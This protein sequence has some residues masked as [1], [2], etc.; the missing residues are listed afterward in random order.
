MFR[1]AAPV[2]LSLMLVSLSGPPRPAEGADASAATWALSRGSVDLGDHVKLDAAEVVSADLEAVRVAHGWTFTQVAAYAA[3]EAALDVVTGHMSSLGPEALV[4]SVIADDPTRPPRVFV[5]G[6]ASP[7]LRTL[8]RELGVA[9]VEDQ[10]YSLLEL[11][12]RLA[13][14]KE[15]ALS[16]GFTSIVVSADI[17]REGAIT[18]VVEGTITTDVSLILSALP[19]AIAKDTLIIV[20][21]GPI[22]EPEGA[23]GGMKVRDSGVFL[24]TSGWTV[25]KVADPIVRGVTSAGHCEGINQI[26][27]PGHG[28]HV[29]FF[30]QRHVGQWGDIEWF[31]TNE[32]EADDFYA[33]EFGSIRDVAAVEP[34]AGI[35]VG[36]AICVYG[37]SSNHRDCSLRVENA[38]V[39]CPGG[40]E[41]LVQMDGDVAIGGDSG[42]GW[43]FN[44]TAYGSHKGNCWYKDSFS[45]ADLFDEALGIAVIF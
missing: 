33:D 9:L 32:F 43:S 7:S 1:S 15:A 10:P 14:V 23:F 12:A 16:E 11:D 22:A 4:G 40:P 29:A 18:L 6:Q 26:D 36:E 20:E 41:K 28:I 38:N 25:K 3:S 8:A 21:A 42:G 45:V 5:K 27:H 44:N 31:M 17:E 39:W 19:P 35:S 13:A 24:C 2:V 34:R 37:R 30:Q